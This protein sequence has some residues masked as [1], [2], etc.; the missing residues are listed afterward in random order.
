[1][2]DIP[3]A[4][5]PMLPFLWRTFPLLQHQI[6]SAQLGATS[7]TIQLLLPA[8]FLKNSSLKPI[9]TLEKLQGKIAVASLRYQVRR[10]DSP[11]NA[12]AISQSSAAVNIQ[13]HQRNE[14]PNFHALRFYL[15]SRT[16]LPSLTKT[17]KDVVRSQAKRFS[18]NGDSLFVTVNGAQKR[19]IETKE[20]RTKILKECHS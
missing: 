4:S 3:H 19:Y 13:R 2:L 9:R 18:L 17:A 16:H 14:E 6:H 5:K 7:K 8:S 12:T 20:E 11:S 1:M 15:R 10:R